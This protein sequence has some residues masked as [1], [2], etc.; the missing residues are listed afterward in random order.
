[1]SDAISYGVTGPVIRSTGVKKDIRFLKSE[2]YAH[3]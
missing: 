1:M 2:T 3:Y